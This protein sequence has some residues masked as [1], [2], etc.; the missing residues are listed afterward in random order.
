MDWQLPSNATELLWTQ[1]SQASCQRL[2]AFQFDYRHWWQFCRQLCK[3]TSRLS[4]LKCTPITV[5]QYLHNLENTCI[6]RL[7]PIGL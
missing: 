3:N 2:P 4:I 6:H 1:A 7:Q 5:T